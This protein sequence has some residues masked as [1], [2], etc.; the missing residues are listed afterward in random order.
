MNAFQ[1]SK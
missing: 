1:A